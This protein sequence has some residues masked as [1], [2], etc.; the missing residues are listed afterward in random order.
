MRKRNSAHIQM[1]DMFLCHSLYSPL[2]R[3]TMES[4]VTW[5]SWRLT[6]GP[7]VPPMK[8]KITNLCIT[9]KG[10][11]SRDLLCRIC[12]IISRFCALFSVLFCTEIDRYTYIFCC[13]SGK[14]FSSLLTHWHLLSIL[15]VWQKVVDLS[16]QWPM[17]SISFKQLWLYDD[18]KSLAHAAN[19][20][21]FIR[22][23]WEAVHGKNDAGTHQIRNHICKH[24][25]TRM[26]RTKRKSC[27]FWWTLNRRV[28]S[29]HTCSML[30]GRVY[31]RH[32]F[33]VA[34]NGV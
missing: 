33:P 18:M 10:S 14:S 26:I 2:N 19:N 9:A 31:W 11:G 22:S 27:L 3:S 30:N 32:W 16:Q 4:W 1:I 23:G 13:M 21:N 28:G 15:L 17:G 29:I 8:Y 6:E 25:R 34:V 12:A 7:I 24:G 20:E 5:Q